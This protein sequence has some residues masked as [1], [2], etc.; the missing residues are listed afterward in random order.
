MPRRKL[1][2]CVDCRVNSHVRGVEYKR[3]PRYPYRENEDDQIE[4]CD[5]DTDTGCQQFLN[6][7]C[8]DHASCYSGMDYT[9]NDSSKQGIVIYT[10][11]NIVLNGYDSLVLNTAL[12]AST[13]EA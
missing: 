5:T 11:D 2:D 13:P 12:K 9:E 4:M 1:S 7:E 10:D 8:E 6:G 3:G